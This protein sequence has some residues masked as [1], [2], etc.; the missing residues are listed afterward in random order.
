MPRPEYQPRGYLS[1]NGKKIFKAIIDH[2]QDAGLD[3]RI[4]VFELTLL[5]NS[6]DLYEVAA[7]RVKTDMDNPEK[8]DK[9]FGTGGRLSTDYQVMLKEYEKIMKHGPKYGLNPG[10]R[11]KIFS[12][13]KKKQKADPSAG[14][15]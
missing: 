15:D 5:A 3:S 2:V 11:A 1:P 13:M 8:R 4:D 10:D 14:L 12:G 7:A 6:F 9:V